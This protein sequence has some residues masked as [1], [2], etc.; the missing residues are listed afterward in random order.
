[1]QIFHLNLLM[2]LLLSNKEKSD[3]NS[4]KVLTDFAG[5]NAQCL[6]RCMFRVKCALDISFPN[7]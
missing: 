6:M 1:M 7:T 3:A 5:E 2:R 4:V